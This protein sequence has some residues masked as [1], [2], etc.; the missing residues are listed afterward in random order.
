MVKIRK[1][2]W[3]QSSLICSSTELEQKW[4]SSHAPYPPMSF[5]L[6][7]SP[8]REILA[9]Q[10]SH[11]SIFHN[12]GIYSFA[13]WQ[14]AEVTLVPSELG[15]LTSAPFF[16]SCAYGKE[17]LLAAW[18]SQHGTF[19]HVTNV[20]KKKSHSFPLLCVCVFNYSLIYTTILSHY[21][22]VFPELFITIF[23]FNTDKA[24]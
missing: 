24:Y 17:Y 22:T 2:I 8:W 7:G 11:N 13:S 21:I 15:V 9:S 20:L 10:C 4:T 23:S 14:C 5:P 1:G 3:G 19:S 18:K 6:D 16:S 12:N